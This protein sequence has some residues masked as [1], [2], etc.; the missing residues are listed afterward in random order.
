ML[1]S[2]VALSVS[3]RLLSV[4]PVE[5]EEVVVAMVVA[6]VATTLAAAEEATVV[7][8]GIV[9]SYHQ[10]LLSISANHIRRGRGL[11]WT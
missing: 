7:E 4:A 9:C 1:D 8:V 3:T 11:W 2:T 5:A 10:S 6:A